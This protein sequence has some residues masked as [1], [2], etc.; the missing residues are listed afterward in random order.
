MKVLFIGNHLHDSGHNVGA[1]FEIADQLQQKGFEILYTSSKVNKILRLL[2]MLWTVVHR[3]EN[4]DVAQVDVF[5]GQAFLWAFLS[6]KI[7]VLLKKPVILTLHGGNLPD[8][9]KKYPSHIR[10]ILNAAST[11]TAP[12]GYLLNKMQNYREDLKLVPNPVDITAYA[13][14]HRIQP[15]PRLVWLRAFHE[16]YNPELAPRVTALLLPAFPDIQLLM[17]GPAKGDGSLHQTR[18]IA[19]SLGIADHLQLPGLISKQDVPLRLNEGDIFL[20][21][22]NIDNTP[23]SLLEAMASG[24][25]VVSTNVGGIPYLVEDGVD[26]L[27]VPSNDSAA[28]AAAVR[29]ILTEPGLAA[30]LSSNARKK[31]EQFD[32]SI[33]LPKWEELLREI[34]ITGSKVLE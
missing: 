16:V 29:R 19:E 28:M 18:Q 27:L 4:Y 3:R 17:I 24:L 30:R 32:W 13:F 9:A 23:V 2:D 33:T 34:N 6:V 14:K 15:R 11:V 7:L 20:N 12:S 1:S 5:S 31:A 25:C 22:T 8:F 26:G 21:T 10:W